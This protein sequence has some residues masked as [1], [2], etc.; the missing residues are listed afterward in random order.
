M[1]LDPDLLKKAEQAANQQVAVTD[2]FV[3]IG[4]G[5]AGAELRGFLMA[6]GNCV[7]SLQLWGL[8]PQAAKGLLA[9]A[10]QHIEQK[11]PTSNVIPVT[12]I[13]PGRLK[14]Q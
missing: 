11:Y 5:G 13:G 6:Q 12:G 8:S 1:G 10:L 14:L 9:R 3:D 7:A 2:T 4:M